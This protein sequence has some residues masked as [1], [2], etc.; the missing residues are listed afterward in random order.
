[1]IDLLRL[2]RYRVISPNLLSIYGDIGDDKGGAFSV[3]HPST[4]VTLRVIAGSGEGWDHVSVSLPHRVPNWY[5][6]QFI[7]R[8]FF[9]PHEVAWEYHLPRSR[10]ISIH[11]H[12]LHLWRKHDFA[13]PLPPET[14]L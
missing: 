12:V 9:E 5:E 10:H 1:M 4:G 2:N 6:M 3:P 13:I 14:M 11:P 7:H 8:L